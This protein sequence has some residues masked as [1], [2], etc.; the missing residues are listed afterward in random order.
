M[1]NDEKPSEMD[2][3]TEYSRCENE[4]YGFI[5]TLVSQRADADELMQETA[6]TLW[7]KNFESDEL[8]R[9]N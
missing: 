3:F 9:D 4:V 5:L 8:I 2:F 6:R 1:T 7:T